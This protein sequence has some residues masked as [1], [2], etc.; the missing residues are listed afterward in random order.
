M[1]SIGRMP[2]KTL[3]HLVDAATEHVLNFNGDA[4]VHVQGIAHDS[5]IVQP[6]DLFVCIPGARADGHL[7][8]RDA[9][10][11]GAVALV[12]ERE[13]G[14]GIPEVVVTDARLAL[15][16]VSAEFFDHPA[17]A[18]KL[19]GITGTNGKTTTA[20]LVESILSAAGETT[21]LIGTIQTRVAGAARAGVRTTPD[22]LDLQRLFAEMRSK[23][24]GAVAMEVTS[25]ALAL[26][27]VRGLRF[28]SSIFTNLTQDHLDFH[29]TMDDYFAAKRGLFLPEMSEK[30]AV[31]IDDPHGRQLFEGLSIEVLSF[32][33][34]PG[35]RV[36]ATDIEETRKG[37]RFDLVVDGESSP[38]SS[39]LIGGFNLSNNL[40]A[41]AG[42]LAAGYETDQVVRGLESLR[43][44]PGRLERVDAGQPFTVVVDYAHTPDSLV[45]VLSTARTMAGEARVI[46]V[47]GCG[48]D[49]D[50]AK[51]PLMGRAVAGA[52]DVVVVTSDNPRS[53]SPAKI[54][55]E[56]VP[57][58]LAERPQG[59]DAVIV[60]RA[61]AI[62]DALSRAAAGDVV[63]IAGKGHEDYQ[64][65]A[66]ERIHF[67]DRE[68]AREALTAMGFEA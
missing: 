50:R 60:D 66:H 11:A 7:F 14:L 46:C 58:V 5:A 4:D 10:L 36:T 35:A 29:G 13:L 33:L 38:V 48:G 32:G 39:Q 19:I 17:S 1:A 8:A 59:P 9:V 23:G 34:T 20:Y 30:A 41:A 55:D 57:G 64:E 25:H 40:G 31:N 42:A 24:V 49:R 52:A 16:L 2:P 12:T 68:V 27:R 15:A 26:E 62:A 61:E 47:F 63:V 18:L 6:G 28:A 54:L 21:G 37:T 56:I 3:K 44:V 53:E 45:N 22:A 43:S 67:D 65:F 51:R